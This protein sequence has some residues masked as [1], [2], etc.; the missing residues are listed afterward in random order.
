[1]I[2]IGDRC[3]R[4]LQIIQNITTVHV[5]FGHL[6]I[7]LQRELVASNGVGFAMQFDEGIAQTVRG[8]RGLRETLRG[9]GIRDEAVLATAGPTGFSRDKLLLYLWPESDEERARHALK[10]AV[11]SL[12]RELGA[13]EVIVG[14]ASLSLN[15]VIITSDAR[16]F[17]M[18]IAAGDLASAVAMYSGPFLDG[19]HLKDSTEFERWSGEQRARFAL[20]LAEGHL[21]EGD[22]VEACRVIDEVLEISRDFGYRR[23]EGEAERLLGESLILQDPA[24]AADH[25][26]TAVQILEEIGAQNELAKALAARAELLRGA[27]NFAAGRRL[28]E[29][30]LAI[31]ERLGTV[32]EPPRIRVALGALGTNPTE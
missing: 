16:E 21:R 27:R 10:Q 2:E 30:A 22:R 26:T 23:V 1:M 14:T 11:Y 25:L 3:L 13:E 15:P 29:D 17:E 8:L 12:R 19:F 5:G 4:I 28:L 7:A 20:W 31:F 24:A 9:H 18:A 6:R 32:D